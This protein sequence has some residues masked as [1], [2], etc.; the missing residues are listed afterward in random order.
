MPYTRPFIC[1]RLHHPG[2]TTFSSPS[3]S[4]TPSSATPMCGCP[5]HPTWVLTS[6]PSLCSAQTS[7]LILL[8]LC[9]CFREAHSLGLQHPMA[10]VPCGRTP[11]IWAQTSHARSFPSSDTCPHQLGSETYPA[12]S[13]TPHTCWDSAGTPFSQGLGSDLSLQT[14]LPRT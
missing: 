11:S 5:A 9:L 3:G 14:A 1:G 12:W 6:V 4:D 8:W 13:L 2:W 7:S 10:G